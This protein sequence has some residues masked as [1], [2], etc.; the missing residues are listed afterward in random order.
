MERWLLDREGFVVRIVKVKMQ[1]QPTLLKHH[2]HKNVPRLAM[3][4]T[5]PVELLRHEN[6]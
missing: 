3:L 6:Q 2:N 5:N 4:L 1:L